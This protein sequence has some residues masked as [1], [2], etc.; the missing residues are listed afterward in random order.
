[1]NPALA[2]ELRP[3][4][5]V[6]RVSRRWRR[7]VQHNMGRSLLALGEVDR[8]GEHLAISGSILRERLGLD[9]PRY[10]IWRIT[11]ADLHLQRGERLQAIE[12]LDAAEPVLL[13][14]FGESSNEVGR[15]RDLQTRLWPDARTPRMPSRSAQ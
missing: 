6:A 12:L 14:A 9:D 4:A 10:S 11:Q 1:M 7:I 8:A 5:S 13:D 3:G 2:P 15:L